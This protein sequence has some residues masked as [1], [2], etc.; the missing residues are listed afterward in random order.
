MSRV[1]DI[2]IDILA[3]AC[4]RLR[5]HL[6]FRLRLWFQMH[7]VCSQLFSNSQCRVVSWHHIHVTQSWTLATGCL[8]PS[9]PSV[10][11]QLCKIQLLVCCGI[12]SQADRHLRRHEVVALCHGW[13]AATRIRKQMYHVRCR[14]AVDYESGQLHIESYL[15]RLNDGGCTFR[16][17]RTNYR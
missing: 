12:S 8:I 1:T 6:R 4:S 3:A 5:R 13:A 14:S 10:P 2:H 17:R 11:T 7:D 15:T 9:F 16:R